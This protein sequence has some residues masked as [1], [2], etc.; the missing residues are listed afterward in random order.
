M[1]DKSDIDERIR[2]CT[3]IL[4]E[5]PSSQIFAALAEAYRKQGDLDKAFRI[6]QNGLKVHPD[7]GSAHLVMAKTNLD[8]GMY[9][10]A[11]SEL[12]KAI[13]LDGTTRATELLLS[14][15]YIYKGEFNKACQIL[16]RLNTGDPGNP[17]I[18][19]LLEIAHKIPM[20]NQNIIN[21]GGRPAA[22]SPGSYSPLNRTPQM[23]RSEK[24]VHQTSPTPS[25]PSLAPTPPPAPDVFGNNYVPPPI[26]VK[27]MDLDSIPEKKLELDNKQL[28]NAMITTPGINGALLMNKDGLVVE[29]AWIEMG[30]T[31]LI[32]AL[33]VE[34][35][36][37]CSAKMKESGM[38]S[39]NSIM[40]ETSQ[41]LFYLSAVKGKILAAICSESVNLGS[42]KLKLNSL[43]P[44]LSA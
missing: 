12:K 7:Y 28:V 21:A 39:L 44:R 30:E 32:G 2:K 29:A 22:P 27:E 42:L 40:I 24:V 41:T 15:I 35:A 1:F 4:D 5:N 13:E 19:K 23:S 10:W 6:C 38:G 26:G 34:A 18:K 8:K 16:E 25:S 37:L 11:E 33:A 36:G 43:L 3:K 17:Q 20:E 31:D 14:E 9:D